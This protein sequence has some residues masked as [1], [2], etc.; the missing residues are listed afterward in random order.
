MN[1]LLFKNHIVNII[2]GVIMVTFS[3]TAYFMEWYTQFLA[4]IIAVVLIILSIKRFIFSYKKAVSKNS[5][6]VLIIEILL[7]F[8]FCGLLAYYQEHIQLYAGLVLYVR[9][10]AYLVINYITTRKVKL[11]QYVLNIGFITFGSFLMFTGYDF[12]PILEIG[13]A[14]FVLLLGAFYLYFGLNTLIKA[15]K[16]KQ[17]ILKK[18]EV[19]QVPPIPVSTVKP[20]EEKVETIEPAK[21]IEKKIEPVKPVEKKV[22]PVVVKPTVNYSKLTVAELRIVAKEK[23]VVGYSSLTKAEMIAKIDKKTKSNL[24]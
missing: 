21:P 18:A 22:E 1:K 16:K 13:V 5:T 23:G 14:A 15:N 20:V 10:V 11:F 9:G 17:L 3:I 6:L 24:G 8:V 4:I 2:I 12:V 7:D 19:K